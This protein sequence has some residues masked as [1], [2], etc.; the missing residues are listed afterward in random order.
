ML[1]AGC[2]PG[3]SGGRLRPRAIVLL[4]T[5]GRD[6]QRKGLG[7]DG[8]GCPG[9]GMQEETRPAWLEAV[10][11]LWLYFGVLVPMGWGRGALGEWSAARH[12]P[13]TAVILTIPRWPTCRG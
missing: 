4:G 13:S 9:G 12:I 2:P 1:E 11:W 6:T 8:W 5:R 3:D 7:H 10:W